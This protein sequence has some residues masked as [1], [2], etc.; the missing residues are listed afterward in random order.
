M[1]ILLCAGA[2]ALASMGAAHAANLSPSDITDPSSQF[3]NPLNGHIYQFVLGGGDWFN[4]VQ[5]ADGKSIGLHRGYLATLTT[6]QEQDFVYASALAFR[7]Q[8]QSPPAYW[9]GA[10]DH[11]NESEWKWRT[12]PEAGLHFWQGDANGG[13]ISGAYQHWDFNADPPQPNTNYGAATEDFLELMVNITW[14]NVT[15]GFWGDDHVN[16]NSNGYIVEYGGLSVPEPTTW[17]LMIIGFGAAG[18]MVRR[19]KA[20]VA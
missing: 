20:M 6:A 4:S 8:N 14:N 12:G 15:N 17:A 9:L 13:S 7:P 10:S 19:R 11:V 5:L 2:M 1:K 3:Y 16:G 18:S